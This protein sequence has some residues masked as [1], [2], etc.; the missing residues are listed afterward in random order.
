M[1]K[2]L[3]ILCIS[4][5]VRFKNELKKYLLEENKHAGI[6]SGEI[7]LAFSM[8]SFS[9]LDNKF[10][11]IVLLLNEDSRESVI[12]QINEIYLTKYRNPNK[13]IIVVCEINPKDYP[14]LIPIINDT[15]SFYFGTAWELAE[16]ISEM[17]HLKKKSLKLS[18][19]DDYEKNIF[20]NESAENSA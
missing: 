11:V 6:Q 16:R 10:D 8:R 12:N 14:L 13:Q 20:N 5:N 1:E 4:G 3:S 19:E 9:Y 7:S 2:L 17:I 15:K 18:Q